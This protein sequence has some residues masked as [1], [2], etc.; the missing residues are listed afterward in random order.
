MTKRAA[1]C[2]ASLT[3]L[4]ELLRSMFKVPTGRGIIKIG[5]HIIKMCSDAN[6]R[7]YEYGVLSEVALSNSITFKVPKVF[8][9]LNIRA[10]SAL[11]MEYVTGHNL[12]N[13]ISDFLLHRSSDAVRIFYRLRRAIRELHDLNLSG[14]HNSRLPSS[15]PELKQGIVELS[16]KLIALKVVD[17][18]LFSAILDLLKSECC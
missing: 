4:Y 6:E 12:D 15:C 7:A 10:H 5:E 1:Y 3:R 13:Y 14:L 18:S 11:I 8:K 2:Y 9:L 16:K 17:N